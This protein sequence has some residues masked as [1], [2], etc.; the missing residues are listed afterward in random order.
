[1]LREQ[2]GTKKKLLFFLFNFWRGWT[3]KHI[4]IGFHFNGLM[5]FPFKLIWLYILTYSKGSRNKKQS[6]NGQSLS[7]LTFCPWSWV[8][9]GWLGLNSLNGIMSTFSCFEWGLM[10]ASDMTLEV[11]SL[12]KP[13]LA[14][15]CL[16][17]KRSF[18]VV[19]SYMVQEVLPSWKGISLTTDHIAFEFC[20]TSVSSRIVEL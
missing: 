3:V 9:T 16:T 15:R 12:A 10:N 14:T 11:Y 6:R 7:I 2:Y 8:A 18:S 1:M 20:Y 4:V 17:N 13:F 19:D 5:E